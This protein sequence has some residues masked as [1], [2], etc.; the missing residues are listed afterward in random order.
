MLCFWFFLLAGLSFIAVYE[1]V[2]TLPSKGHD[3]G[4]AATIIT[5]GSN[6]IGPGTAVYIKDE[7]TLCRKYGL[8][9]G[10]E[11]LLDGAAR[12][13]LNNLSE[14][15]LRGRYP[16]QAGW[17]ISWERN[18]VVIR[19]IKPGL[20]PLHSKRWHLAPDATGDNIAVYLGPAKVGREGGV[21]K[22]TGIR[23][24]DLPVDLRERVRN[25]DFEFI[26]WDDLVATL[27]SLDE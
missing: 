25:N 18:K 26:D 7:Y 17:E 23:I 3:S 13:Q 4:R 15:E 14:D 20:C 6:V 12:D 19:Q 22:E 1:R 11:A 10:D 8:P 27:D 5:A 9:C 21:V 2:V 24:A 16:Q